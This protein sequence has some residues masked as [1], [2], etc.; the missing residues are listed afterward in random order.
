M[1]NEMFRD[2]MMRDMARGRNGRFVRDGRNPYG[3][4]GGYIT[5]RDPRRRDRAYEEDYARGGRRDYNQDYNDYESDYA[6]G[7][8]G[9]RGGQSDR[10]G[11][12]PFELMGRVGY[13]EMFDPR[14]QEEL[15][16]D[17]A[18]GRYGRDYGGAE[19]LSN[20]DLMEWS[21]RLMKEV[22]EKDKPFFKYE[23]IE[24]KAKEMGI[25]FDKFSFDEFYTTVLM[26]F[27]DYCK[28]L[29]TANLDIYLRLAK[30]WLCD[31]DVSMKYGEKLASYY[32]Y[33]VEGM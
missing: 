22:E 25:Q 30:D 20:R 33:V 13:E 28:T 5:S 2:M 7:G 19:M 9:G 3:S 26:M 31:E 32:D 18:G 16:Y 1:N 8:R 4:R 14:Y 17:Y 21:Q 10:H 15:M 24:K 29:G 12:Y 6:R 23:N 27:T 11:F